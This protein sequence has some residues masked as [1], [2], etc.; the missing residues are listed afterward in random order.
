[1]F[2]VLLVGMRAI[3][4]PGSQVSITEAFAAW[5][6]TRLLSSIPITPGGIGILDIGL[7]GAL[8]GFGGEDAKV[9]AIVLLYRVITFV[10]PIV[11]GAI[12][13]FTWRRHPE[14]H[15]PPVAP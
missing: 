5:S 8:N 12:A 14:R 3:G 9:V 7:A 13:M 15:L 1:M 4:L 11:L 10:P 2:F 6:V